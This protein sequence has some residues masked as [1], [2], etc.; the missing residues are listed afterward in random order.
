MIKVLHI[1]KSLDIGGIETLALDLCNRAHLFDLE[2]HVICIGGGEL[3]AEF[4]KSPAYFTKIKKWKF[5]NDTV[6]PNVVK[7]I[8][9]Y[10]KKHQIKIIHTHF[11]DEGVHAVLAKQGLKDIKIIQTFHVD[12]RRV[13][14]IDLLRFK[15]VDNTSVLNL[16]PSEVL[17]QQ[18]SDFKIGNSTKNQTLHNGINPRRVVASRNNTLRRH[19]GLSSDNI[20][21]GM[22]G[23]FYSDIRDH[24]TVCKALKKVVEQHKNFHFVFVGGFENKWVNKKSSTYE[25][26]YDFCKKNALFKQVHFLGLMKNTQEVFAELDF[27]VHASNFDTFGMAPIEAMM[28][29]LPVIA[30]DFPVFKEISNNGAG[31]LLFEDKNE[32]D[33]ALK[34]SELIEDKNKRMTLA[35]QHYHFANEKYHIDQHIK[36]L[37]NFYLSLL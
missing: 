18:L 1:L 23:N 33:L 27:Y 34:I 30:N 5:T 15:W 11:A 12:C 37:R 28:N 26:C 8:R 7:G 24:L 13:R 6:S 16:S 21:A 9:D 19:L 36:K 31:M 22:V 29:K 4:Q 17:T 14:K 2:V 32:E 10:L 3:E 35:E 25:A 20:L